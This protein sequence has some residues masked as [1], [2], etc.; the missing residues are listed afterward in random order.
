MSYIA[1]DVVCFRLALPSANNCIRVARLLI[2]G[3]NKTFKRG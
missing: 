3:R 2:F 1:N